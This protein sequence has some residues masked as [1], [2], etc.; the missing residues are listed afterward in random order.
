LLNKATETDLGQ[1]LV[2]G[3]TLGAYEFNA[4]KKLEGNKAKAKSIKI[5]C[6]DPEKLT[7][8]KVLKIGKIRADGT[9]MARTLGNTPA[10]DLKPKDLAEEAK[11]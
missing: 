11:K 4:Y 1:V 7:S 3:L 2:E 10:N 9:N 6:C 8:L 5:I